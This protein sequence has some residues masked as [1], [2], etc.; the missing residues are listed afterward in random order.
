MLALGLGRIMTRMT[1]KVSILH[2][3]Y[4]NPRKNGVSGNY[5]DWLPYPAE[6]AESSMPAMPTLQTLQI[7][8]G[9]TI[10]DAERDIWRYG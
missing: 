9:R 10:T 4:N 1:P 5:A 6:L 2:I 8:S 3:H 7:R